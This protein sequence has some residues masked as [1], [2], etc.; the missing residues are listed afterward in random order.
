VKI[1]KFKVATKE[2][3]KSTKKNDHKFLWIEER[4]RLNDERYVAEM[5]KEKDRE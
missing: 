4:R 3:K 1:S 5:I 2:R